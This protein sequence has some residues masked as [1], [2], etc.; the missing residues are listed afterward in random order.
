MRRIRK[1]TGLPKRKPF[2]FHTTLS[3]ISSQ[4]NSCKLNVDHIFGYWSAS[5]NHSYYGNCPFPLF[6]P[7]APIL[8]INLT[9]IHHHHIYLLPLCVRH[10]DSGYTQSMS[11]VWL[12]KSS[13]TSLVLLNKDCLF[14]HSTHL[15]LWVTSWAFAPSIAY[16]FNSLHWSSNP[17]HQSSTSEAG[18]HGVHAFLLWMGLMFGW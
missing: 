3:T 14:N 6:T 17:T 11:L 2:S 10:F 12:T 4:P 5:S 18:W 13:L 16:L 8:G 15:W 1:P 7:L 9:V